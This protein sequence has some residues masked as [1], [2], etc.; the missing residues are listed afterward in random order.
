MTR[1]GM[2]LFLER[3]GHRVT[4]S[5]TCYWYDLRPRFFLAFPHTA[6][7]SPGA[8]ELDRVF[9][10]SGALGLRYV[11][12]LDAA[13]RLSWALVVDDRAYDLD[14]LTANT[15]SKVRRGLKRCEVLPV[16]PAFV[17]HHGRR[18]NDD[19]L[20]RLRFEQDYYPW[21]RYWDA[22]AA[23]GDAE[24]W[25]ALCDGQVAAF[26]VVVIVEGCAEI[27]VARSRT[28][29]LT[30]YPNNALL[31]QVVHDLIRRDD[32]DRVLFGLESLD[33][34]SGVDAFKESMGFSRLPIRQRIVFRP[35]T[36]RL[37]RMPFV[38]RTAR[39]LA[40]RRPGSEFWRKVEGVLIFHGSLRDT[41]EAREGA[42]WTS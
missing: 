14:R 40:R 22:V 36:E 39:A 32:V 38:S 15:R 21:D 5:R 37:L 18:A 1:D 34:V 8:G 24:V 19:T 31:F 35:L 28:D 3:L 10:A 27:L 16:A 9:A 41:R 20:A 29:L 2:A 11:A 33:M 13:G 23:T 7:A 42:S 25:A 26:L 6:Q 30:H 17:R 4:L 12:P